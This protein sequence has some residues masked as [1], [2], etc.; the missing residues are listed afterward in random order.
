MDDCV[1]VE[2]ARQ[3]SQ[4]L[5][6]P[7]TSPRSKSIENP[8]KIGK[9]GV[10]VSPHVSRKGKEKVDEPRA[11]YDASTNQS[12]VGGDS[13]GS[14][15]SLDEELGILT[16]RTPGVKKAMEAMNSNL[17]RSKHI[18]NPVQRLSYDSYLAHH[19][20]YMANVVQVNETTCVEEAIGNENWK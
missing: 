15:M 17:R 11:V 18:K 19:Y 16:M 10:Q 13:S 12:I 7:S 1:V 6:G 3:E 9:I 14:E 4:V 5:S 2:T 20:A 8:W